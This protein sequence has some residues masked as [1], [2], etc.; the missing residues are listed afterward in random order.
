MLLGTP[1][2]ALPL[3]ALKAGYVPVPRGGRSGMSCT[4][5]STMSPPCLKQVPKNSLGLDPWSCGG[6]LLFGLL[7]GVC[8]RWGRG[9]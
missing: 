3:S 8:V 2:T 9:C 5:S 7:K 6:N 4:V 1:S